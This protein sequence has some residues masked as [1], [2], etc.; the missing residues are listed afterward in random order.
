MSTSHATQFVVEGVA[1][2]YPGTIALDGVDLVIN[3]GEV[4]A[5]LGENGAGK[6]TLS[7][8]IAGLTTPTSGTMT[9]R[10]EPYAPTS[11]GDAIGHGIGMIHQ[12]MRLLPELTVAEN[13]M[14]GRWP[15]RRGLI[16]QSKM[17]EEASTY[18]HQLGFTG[19]LDQRVRDLSV[20]G[21]QQ[22][23]I[24]KALALN[25]R[26]LILDE[27]TAAL[28]QDETDALFDTVRRLRDQP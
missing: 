9:W 23:E 16:S 22:V 25:A 11:P 3:P 1:K 4:V 24:A 8:I 18:L 12:E 7:G 20:A 19:R 28:G 13:V 2:H 10:G 26:L 15:S 14:V 21:Q 17:A 5:L 27:P 6:S